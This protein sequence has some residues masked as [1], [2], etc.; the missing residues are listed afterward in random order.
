MEHPQGEKASTAASAPRDVLLIYQGPLISVGKSSTPFLIKSMSLK[1]CK[2]IKMYRN[3]P[4]ESNNIMSNCL[5]WVMASQRVSCYFL[6]HF[7]KYPS[8]V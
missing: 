7:K 8:S 5:E 2:Y 4:K 6:E 3:D 1:E